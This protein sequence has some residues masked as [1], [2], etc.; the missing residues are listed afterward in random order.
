M[1]LETQLADSHTDRQ[2]HHVLSVRDRESEEEEGEGDDAP[3]YDLFDSFKPERTTSIGI[4]RSSSSPMVPKRKQRR[5]RK[6][7]DMH[8]CVCDKNLS[9]SETYFEKRTGLMGNGTEPA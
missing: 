5:K 8:A 7:R 4:G 3:Y 2:M 1:A 6:R 9:H